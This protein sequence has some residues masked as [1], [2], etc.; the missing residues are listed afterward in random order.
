MTFEFDLNRVKNTIVNAGKEVENMAK[1]VSA[2]AKLKMDIRNKEN[3]LEKQYALL[4][5]AFYEA[6]KE[7]EVEESVYFLSIKEVQEELARLK[8]DLLA[9]QGAVECPDCGVKVSQDAAFCPSC[10]AA[11][12]Q[13]AESTQATEDTE[14]T[15]TVE[16]ED[17]EILE[18]VETVEVEEICE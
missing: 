9:A 16:V 4:G 2:T 13:N 8:A 15:E 7:E 17:A 14:S 6:H 18:E 3:F 10:G 12:K 11:L 1:D 5:K